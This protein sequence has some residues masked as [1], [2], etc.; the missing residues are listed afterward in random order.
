MKV[1]LYITSYFNSSLRNGI[2]NKA[3]GESPVHKVT[4]MK[5]LRE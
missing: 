2:L 1:D 5:E 4:L 3:I